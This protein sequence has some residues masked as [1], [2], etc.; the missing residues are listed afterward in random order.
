MSADPIRIADLTLARDAD[1]AAAA[2]VAHIERTTEVL[3]G[4]A[5]AVASTADGSATA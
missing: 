1:G 5:N 3:I 4:Y 2:L